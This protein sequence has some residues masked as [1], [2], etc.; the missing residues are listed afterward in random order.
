MNLSRI[1]QMLAMGN[2]IEAAMDMQ[3]HW[4]GGGKQETTSNATTTNTPTQT[5]QYNNLLSEADSWLNNG[6]LGGGGY[7]NKSDG[8]QA[9]TYGSI[10]NGNNLN[11]IYTTAGNEALWQML[12]N[13]DPNATGLNGAIDASNNRLDFNYNTQVA[14]QVA[15]G[16]IDTGQ[17]GSTRNGVAQGIA[18]S[19]LSQQKA[20]SANTLAFQDQQNFNNNR[21]AA[22]QSLGQITQG[23]NSGN[24]LAYDTQEQDRLMQMQALAAKNGASLQDLL[25]Y[26]Q[27]ISGDYGGTSTTNGTSSVKGGSGGGLLGG[28]GG[29]ISNVGGQFAGSYA[30]AAGSKAGSS[31]GGLF[32]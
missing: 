32:G 3:V 9:N 18:L 16:A 11:G 8:Q 1:Q 4:K 23:L 6:G 22:Y 13:Y 29:I 21:L 12:G 7:I 14:P 19:N 28:L 30:G 15:Q 31:S 17:Y 2:S 24:Q 10:I 27:L 5:P 25:A 20:D 26:Q